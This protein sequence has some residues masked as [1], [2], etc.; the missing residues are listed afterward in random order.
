LTGNAEAGEGYFPE[1]TAAGSDPAHFF[2]N[3]GGAETDRVR[4]FYLLAF[5]A[6]RVNIRIEMAYFIPCKAIR[7]ALV[8]AR[9]RG[10]EVEIIVP[11]S[12]NNS[13]AAR[14]MS[15]RRYGELL[16]AGVR[17][18]E[19]Q[20]S[21]FHTKCII[22]DDALV[23]VGSANMDERTYRHNDE[24]NLNVLS[25]GFAASQIRVFE[26]DKQRAHEV[27]QVD[28]KRRSPF[29]RLAECLLIPCEPLY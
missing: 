6:A 2:S 5:E 3:T 8:N 18:Y 1:L 4:L 13:Q 20:P 9:R 10:V 21:M 19:Y 25:P 14:H 7:R 22:V 23:S 12:R 27:T 24:A 17:I 11:N 26:A 16:A 15:R 29:S 28:W